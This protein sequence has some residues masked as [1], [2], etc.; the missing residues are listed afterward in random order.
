[1]SLSTGQVAQRDGLV[2]RS[3]KDALAPILVRVPNCDGNKV[4]A[5]WP[6]VWL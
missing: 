1:M 4:D 6:G 5:Q 3:T 2:A